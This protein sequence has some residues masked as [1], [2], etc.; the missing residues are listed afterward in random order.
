MSNQKRFVINCRVRCFLNWYLIQCH[1]LRCLFIDISFQN[2]FDFSL[3]FDISRCKL[4]SHFHSRA[5]IFY[6]TY[7]CGQRNEQFS[8]DHFRQVFDWLK[9]EASGWFGSIVETVT[10]R[11][12]KPLNYTRRTYLLYS[13]KNAK[14]EYI[15]SNLNIIDGTNA[16]TKREQREANGVHEW[17]KFQTE[18]SRCLFSIVRQ[19]KSIGPQRIHFECT[20][21]LI[22]SFD[23]R[24]LVGSA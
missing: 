15:K 10:S 1:I 20:W 19:W 22:T 8:V 24:Q 14:F 2:V 6:F 12:Q 9:V 3:H 21:I 17:C 23:L 11:V 4:R 7:L 13:R 5:I 18:L 16:E